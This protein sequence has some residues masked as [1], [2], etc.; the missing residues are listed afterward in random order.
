MNGM[1]VNNNQ[2]AN[3]LVFEGLEGASTGRMYNS[4][5]DR[6]AQS[7]VEA[8]NHFKRLIRGNVRGLTL[9]QF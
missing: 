8:L 9:D 6:Y 2:R 4:F 5:N 1:L 3:N 7:Y